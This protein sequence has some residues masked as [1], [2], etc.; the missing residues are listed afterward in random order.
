MHRWIVAGAMMLGCSA[1]LGASAPGAVD[2]LRAIHELSKAEAARALPVEFEAT[3][4]YYNKS[5]VDL[6]VQDA[7]LGI[8]VQA[9]QNADL[10]LGDR[11][12]VR[13]HTRGSFRTDIVGDSI[14]VLHHGTLPKSQE[15]DFDR[16]IS[17]QLDATRVT[18]HA[19]VRSADMV[20]DEGR[21][22]LYMHL[23]M[24]GG[25]VDATVVA[26]NAVQLK[27][28]LDSEVEVTGVVAGK[29]DSKDQLT[30]IL[31]QIPSLDGVKILK[32]AG[33]TPESLPITPM[34][35][36][37]SG[38][39]VRDLTRRIRVR[40]TI[41]Y[42]EPGSAIVLQ[43]GTKSLWINTQSEMSHHIGALADVT[44][45]PNA[46]GGSLTMSLGQI[47]D[48]EVQAPITP[49]PVTE[50]E[51]AAGTHEFELV[52][53]EGE[54]LTS[55]R[56]AAQ[57]EYVLVS[58]GHVFSAVY[59]HLDA[60]DGFQLAPMKQIPVGS[61][62]RVTG[63]SMVTYGSNPFQGPVSFRLLMRSFD[64]I[65]VVGNPSWLSVRNLVRLVSVL[66]LV[67]LTI[68]VRQWIL[69]R[70]IHRQTVA[71][72]NRIEAKAALERR[73]AQL[74]QRRSRILEDING[75]RPLAEIIE[76]IAGLV[77][78]TLGDC[79]CWCEIAA[80]ATLGTTTGIQGGRI[81][82][83]EIV[84]HNGQVV[85]RIYV[86]P[87]DNSASGGEEGEALTVGARLA[88]LAIET[89]R[90]YSDLV[91]RS[92]F[93]QLTQVHNRFSLDKQLERCIAE[94]REKAGIFGLIYVDLDK[95]KL[96]NDHYGHRVGD[97]Y[98]QEVARRM[99][100]QLRTIDVLAR[101]GGDEFAALIPAVRD[102]SD[103]KDVAMRLERCFDEPFA[104]EG[105]VL[106]GSA[107]I[108]MATYPEDG[109]TKD[110]LLTAADADMYVGKQ[111]RHES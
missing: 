7:G 72:A 19:M 92:E 87:G 37:L 68:A 41:T 53:A 108:G 77:S 38:Y 26:V 36:I 43:S 31:L 106:R 62:V 52:S 66:V 10:A 4:T 5:D 96:V 76:H 11:V 107:S 50:S 46:G 90:I 59:H 73:M 84:S 105:Y 71:L 61:R 6:F 95:F 49:Q 83:H 67:V 33:I 104:V 22:N 47:W 78:F 101:L 21:Y 20:V 35:Q 74:E 58:N 24:D 85:G 80:G 1:A 14:T 18:F 12:L 8:Y 44:G 88:A 56:Q 110:S 79:P 39:H 17:G 15:A 16:M 55:V 34:D 109:T 64:D 9:T 86:A 28:L 102:S 40:G 42:F 60:A 99:A 29:F 93:D 13:G 2:S 97:L 91:Y 103:V 25:H 89:R 81:L 63:I 45:F 51:L 48:S 23:L 3:V 82:H 65:V 98:L 54:V 27:K 111:T 57:D 32:E 30:G 94:A 70:K 100:G 69:E 75:S